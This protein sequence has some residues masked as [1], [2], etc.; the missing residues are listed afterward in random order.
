MFA[1]CFEER[2]ILRRVQKSIRL[3]ISK[4]FGIFVGLA[5][6]FLTALIGFRSFVFSQEWPA[7]GDVLSH[8]S[9]EYLEKDYRWLF[10]WRDKSFGYVEGI[11]LMDLFFALLNFVSGN[12]PTTAKVF[13]FLSY[14]TAGFAM[15]AFG[16]HYTRKNIPALAGSLIYILNPWIFSQLTEAH[17]DILFSYALAPTIFLFLDRAL[18]TRSAKDVLTSSFLFAIMLTS[19]HQHAIF[20]YTCFLGLFA[21]ILALSPKLGSSFRGNIKHSLK[22]LLKIGILG[23]ALSAFVWMPLLFNV[24]AYY[25]TGGYGF[26]LE[27][28]YVYG[29][30]NFVEAFTLAAKE[31]G[32][33]VAIV[34]VTKDVGLQI[35]PVTFMLLAVLAVSY[36]TTFISKMDRYSVFFGL[37]ALVSVIISM[38]PYSPL[39]SS[40][41]WAWFNIPFFT[42]FRTTS[43]WA[44]MTALSNSF[45]VCTSVSVATGYLSKISQHNQKYSDMQLTS[46]GSNSESLDKEKTR[47]STRFSSRILPYSKRFL[48]HSIVIYLVATLLIGPFSTWFF[49]SHGL[50]VY[51]PPDSY[52]D[53]YEYLASISGDYKIVTVGRSA[54]DWYSVS[55]TDT[56]FDYHD[57][58]TAI[59]W[60]H[61][62]G[63]DSSFIH[64]KPVLQN[65][66][67]AQ[68]SVDFVNYLR[69]YLA[70][71]NVSRNLWKMLGAFNYKYI[72]IPSYVTENVRSFI[73]LQNGGRVIYNESNSI[74][75]ENDFY[76]PRMTAPT[77]VALVFGDMKTLSSL[78]DIE[79]FDLNRTALILSHQA[80]NFA[81]IAEHLNDC[82]TIIFSEFDAQNDLALTPIKDF[83]IIYAADYGVNSVNA[84]QYWIKSEWLAE[85]GETLLGD[86]TL[87]TCGSNSLRIPFE[88][89]SDGTYEVWMRIGFDQNRGKLLLS[90]DGLPMAEIMPQSITPHVGWVRVVS[91]CSLEAGSHVI[92]VFN[93]GTGYNDIDAI[94]IPRQDQVQNR[95]KETLEAFQGFQGKILCIAEGEDLFLNELPSG[96]SVDKENGEGYY[97]HLENETSASLTAS[98]STSSEVDNFVAQ[99]AIDGSYSTR[100]AS[101]DSTPQ[102]LELSWPTPQELFGVTVNFER[103]VAKDYSIQAWNGTD[104]IDT[105]DVKDNDLLRRSHIFP[106]PVTTTKLRLYVTSAPAFNMVSVFEL[107]TRSLSDMAL[108]KVF[109][110]RSGEYTLAARLNSDRKPNGTLCVKIDGNM[111]CCDSTSQSE[112]IW[113]QLGSMFLERGE[114]T[115]NICALGDVNLDKIGLY[116]T[117]NGAPLIDRFFESNLPSPYISYEKIDPCKYVVHVNSTKPFLLMFSESYHPMWKAYVHNMEIPPVVVDTLANG[118]FINETG[119]FDITLCFTGQTYVDLSL[120]ISGSSAFLIIVA[121]SIRSAPVRRLLA[122]CKK[123]DPQKNVVSHDSFHKQNPNSN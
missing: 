65:G 49:F 70:G 44:M 115:I 83:S 91:N 15:Y 72:V 52:V 86:K 109:V 27:E 10:T 29:Y 117:D 14:V 123:R 50:E 13:A 93:D 119:N 90:I 99:N 110:P 100:W 71:N 9:R 11:N 104:W 78:Y 118:F 80:D 23:L 107:E 84:T 62:L 31:T 75:L 103:A 64:D 66:G 81:S 116:C 6:I 25:L 106:Q 68:P 102:W 85:R 36:V 56:D 3:L 35:L 114:H 28:T 16:Y 19:F 7:G 98:V 21:V 24:R 96:W 32:G 4:R 22:T 54:L 51:T 55:G 112:F 67:W 53:P 60:S 89:R 57:M 121:V 120:I 48:H 77:Q 108:S 105:I 76:A 43:R 95:I 12:A 30:R 63:S 37:S 34:D 73:M 39:G 58:L 101:S 113:Q 5:I 74:I 18:T 88:A 38:G 1:T 40:F 20:I 122:R 47:T 2:H 26:T 45:F 82:S 94:A 33:Y 42:V 97:L 79:S 8:I 46:T 61:D 92:N 69:F 111:F 87:M 41:T 59:G 17:L